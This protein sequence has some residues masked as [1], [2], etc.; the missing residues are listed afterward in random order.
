MCVRVLPGMGVADRDIAGDLYRHH[1]CS[2]RNRMVARPVAI[3]VR[4][5]ASAFAGKHDLDQGR[6][7]TAANDGAWHLTPDGFST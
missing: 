5:P 2:A 1:I 3:L 4:C 7:S 6:R